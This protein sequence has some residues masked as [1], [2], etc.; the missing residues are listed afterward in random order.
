MT[1]GGLVTRPGRV[2]DAPALAAMLNRIIAAGGTTAMEAP[3]TPDAFAEWFITG[4][5]ALI[6]AVV[7]HQ[8]GLVGF[9]SLSD[10]YPLPAGWADIGTFTRR[11]DP[12]PGAGRALFA[13]T[14]AA[15]RARGVRHL[16]ATIRADN[17]GG[18]AFY[19]KLGFMQY[20]LSPDVPLAD[21]T[22]IDR[23]HHRFDL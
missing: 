8:G 13:A 17:S 16:N 3:L 12:V 20:D 5:H 10:Y 1:G 14:C 21:G 4:R 23:L 2:G 9:Q 6:C 11:A 7:E 19:R 22:P 18:L 15:A